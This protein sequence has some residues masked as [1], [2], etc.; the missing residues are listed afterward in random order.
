M[1]ELAQTPRLAV[2]I[3]VDYSV[4]RIMETPPFHRWAGSPNSDDELRDVV[5]SLHTEVQSALSPRGM[6]RAI[7]RDESGIE[8]YDPPDRLRESDV[9]V[10]GV[11]T[12]GDGITQTDS[13]DG[14]LR[15]LVADAM[16]NVALQL[17]RASLLSEIKEWGVE[18]GYQTTR[19]FPPGTRGEEWELD[20]RRFMFETL[21]TELIDVQLRKGRITDP[22]KTFAFAMG[23]GT[24]IEQAELL[25]TCADCE[26]VTDCPYVGTVVE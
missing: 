1:P 15:T 18:N 8:A 11:L 7:P 17:A 5:E 3:D 12:I 23:L 13:L 25:L 14:L 19:V 6:Y 21:E 22:R 20:T 4:D 10:P 9:I 2:P 16:E 26:Y 24:D